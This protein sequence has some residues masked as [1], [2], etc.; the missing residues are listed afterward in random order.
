MIL[1]PK[2]V[3]RLILVG[4]FGVLLQL[5]FFS[6]IELFHVSPDI[7]PALVVCLG[8]LG[9][10]MTGAVSG[11]AIG[12]LLDCLLIQPLG[13]ASLVLIAVGY[14]AGIFRERFE[15][16]SRL[17]APLLCALLTF[18]AEL[19]FGAVEAMF[20]IDTEVSVL[21]LRDILIQSAGPERLRLLPRLGDLRR[22]AAPRA[23]GP[24]RR[25]DGAADA[26]TDGAG[27][28]GRCTSGQRTGRDRAAWRCGS[29]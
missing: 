8:L 5:T 15:I 2:I 1:T 26:T 24:G 16:H 18:A 4:L 13:G 17:V 14:A 21:V 19:G 6:Q 7:L 12:F 28:V 20:G 22:P 25:G 11:F 23:A 10:S 3:V 27:S 9:G 29:R